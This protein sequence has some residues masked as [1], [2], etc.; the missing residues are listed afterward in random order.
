M[1]DVRGRLLSAQSSVQQMRKQLSETDSAKR[2]AE[3]RTQAVQ[4]ERDTAQREREAVQKE[5]ERL[6]QERDA[7]ARF[8]VQPFVTILKKL[9]KHPLPCQ[10]LTSPFALL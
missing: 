1:Q 6:R 9:K 7:L 3:Q 4:R 8:A 5:K 2:D 10:A